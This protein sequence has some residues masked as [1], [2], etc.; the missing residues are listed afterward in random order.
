MSKKTYAP[1]KVCCA[2]C[3]NERP[4]L[5]EYPAFDGSAVF[6]VCDY[7]PN[8]RQRRWPLP[9]KHYEPK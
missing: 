5:H 8:Y 7:Q 2:D 1:A 6:S 4:V 3:R 9:C